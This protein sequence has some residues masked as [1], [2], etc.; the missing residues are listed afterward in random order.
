MGIWKW[1][2]KEISYLP[3]ILLGSWGGVFLT[4]CS[5]GYFRKKAWKSPSTVTFL[6]I[7]PG[8]IQLVD[9]EVA[10]VDK[11]CNHKIFKKEKNWE[12]K[13]QCT[14]VGDQK[15]QIIMS[16]LLGTIRKLSTSYKWVFHETKTYL[17]KYKIFL[18]FNLPLKNSQNIFK[19]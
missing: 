15:Y 5:E 3:K 14:I 9:H 10:F 16:H 11:Q 1:D 17:F 6:V 13:F 18:T 4:L 7:K 19:V 8:K 2:F 12:Q